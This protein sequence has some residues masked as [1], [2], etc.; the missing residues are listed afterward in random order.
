MAQGPVRFSLVD[1]CFVGTNLKDKCYPF[2]RSA[3]PISK[4]IYG[5]LDLRGCAKKQKATN[6]LCGLITSMMF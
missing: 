3:G 6:K 1:V 2:G 4:K 5:V